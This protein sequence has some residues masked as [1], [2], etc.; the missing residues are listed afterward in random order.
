M[1][2]IIHLNRLRKKM[3]GV[4]CSLVCVYKCLENF[5]ESPAQPKVAAMKSIIESLDNS[6]DSLKL[7]VQS[8][9][10]EVADTEDGTVDAENGDRGNIL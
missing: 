8:L 4:F 7:T 3:L 1:P 6:V 2:E 5:A 10:K 9:L